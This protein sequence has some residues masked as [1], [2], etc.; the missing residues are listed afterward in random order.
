MVVKHHNLQK[1]QEI[2]YLK[3]GEND[4]PNQ[5]KIL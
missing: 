5:Q 3:I 4:I 1:D 2:E